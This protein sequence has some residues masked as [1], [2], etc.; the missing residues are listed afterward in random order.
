MQAFE[1]LNYFGREYCSASS[2]K[3]CLFSGFEKLLSG[4]LSYS[5][6]NIGY[7]NT[8]KV[9]YESVRTYQGLRLQ[10]KERKL[11]TITHGAQPDYGQVYLIQAI[12]HDN[13]LPHLLG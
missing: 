10:G 9:S 13:L 7:R 3:P 5:F 11:F 8:K 2:F 6:Y 12:K 4:G 1:Q